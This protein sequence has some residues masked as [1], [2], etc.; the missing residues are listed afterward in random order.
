MFRDGGLR[1]Q[2]AAGL[3]PARRLASD[4]ILEHAATLARQR[5]AVKPKFLGL[6]SLTKM[7]ANRIRYTSL[8]KW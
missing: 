2:V 6:F 4:P 3:W 5:H 7:I 1:Y 8:R